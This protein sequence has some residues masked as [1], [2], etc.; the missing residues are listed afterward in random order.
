MTQRLGLSHGLSTWGGLLTVWWPQSSQTQGSRAN[1]LT[2]KVECASLF[3][4]QPQQSN[5]IIFC[6]LYCLNNHKL[7]QIQGKENGL[8]WWKRGKVTLGKSMWKERHWPSLGNKSATYHMLMR[9]QGHGICSSP[10]LSAPC[11]PVSLVLII[12]CTCSI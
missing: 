12:Y 11:L 3:M 9:R 5:S 6:L 7:A 2:N 8:S 4:N 1:I 10:L